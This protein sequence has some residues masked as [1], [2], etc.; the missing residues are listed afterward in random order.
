M[1]K[2]HS[3]LAIAFFCLVFARAAAPADWV[4]AGAAY[5]EKAYRKAAQHYEGL[6]K[7]GYHSEAL[8]YNLGNCYV[9]TGE[10]G[11]A[12]LAYEN[13]LRIKPGDPATE[14]NLASVRAALEDPVVAEEE[15]YRWLAV[16]TNPQRLL[17]SS[18]WLWIGL[19]LLWAGTAC[20]SAGR[21]SAGPLRPGFWKIGMGT[22][23][24]IG[25]L[26]TAFG[27]VGHIREQGRKEAVVL[28]RELSLLTAPDTL[29]P[30]L[31][32][33]HEGAK[34]SIL[35]RS[36]TWRKVRLPNGDEGWLEE[37]AQSIG[38]VGAWRSP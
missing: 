12:V 18:Y 25:V 16:L 13:A 31:R 1:Q 14:A 22:A 10:K 4:R 5:R 37:K 20:W 36:G 24:I 33:V 26:A 29:S 7:E 32:K 6:L 3:T 34:V 28:A 17:A 9:Q 11:K 35:D 23:W 21:L 19:V 27:I 2:K 15:G 8:W 30:E 38:V